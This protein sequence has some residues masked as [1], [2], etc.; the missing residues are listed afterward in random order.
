VLPREPV[1][2]SILIVNYRAY[3]ELASCLESLQ[4]FPADD[5]EVIVVDHAT[6]PSA[7]ADLRGRFPSIRLIEVSSNPGFAAGVNRAARAARGR[8]FLLLNPDCIADGDVPHTLAVW[9]E[10]HPRAGVSGALVREADG[11]VQASARRFPGV[12]TGFAGRTSWLT[13][14][15]PEN[16]W[17]RRNLVSPEVADRP[18]E[19]DW[20]SGACLMVRR[21]AFEAV[22]GMDERFFMY[23]EDADFC[24]RL[25]QAG[26]LTF[27]NPI[28]AITHLTGR[29]SSQARRASL[30]AFHRSAFRY[31]R[32]HGG[33]VARAAAPVVFL[34]LSA[35]LVLKLATLELTRHGIY[36]RVRGDR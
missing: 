35:R 10:A 25:R 8:Y 5:L 21:T 26:W 12:T 11:S 18:I 19:V 29:S 16:R 34:T 13:R 9:L 3:T 14:L 15:W 24:F 22:G 23:W 32:K 20:V 4:R 7:A 33:R 31:F 1:L 17:T 6:A 28:V 30:I 36:R 27:Y 2:V